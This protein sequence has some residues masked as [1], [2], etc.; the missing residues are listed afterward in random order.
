[1]L[2]PLSYVARLGPTVAAA[3]NVRHYPTVATAA[4]PLRIGGRALLDLLMQ[5]G[6]THEGLWSHHGETEGLRPAQNQ[7]RKAHIP[8]RKPLPSR[9]WRGALHRGGRCCLSV[10]AETRP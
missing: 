1:M 7:R 3:P 4:R 9:S 10:S 2:S 8:K 5:P 6:Q